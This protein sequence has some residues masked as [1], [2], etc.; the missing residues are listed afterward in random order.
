[1]SI[2]S[3]CVLTMA[4]LIGLVVVTALPAMAE[5][6]RFTIR[7][8]LVGMFP[9]STNSVDDGMG[10]RQRVDLDDSFGGEFDFEWYF[11]DRWGLEASILTVVDADFDADDLTGSDV[12][13]ASGLAIT[14]MTFGINWHAIRSESFDWYIGAVVG[15]IFYGDFDYLRIDNG[16]NVVTD[17]DY[18]AD[19]DVAYGLQTAVDLAVTKHGKWAVNIGLKYLKSEF[20]ADILD[21]SAPTG[22]R[23]DKIKID[24]WLL[25]VMGVFRF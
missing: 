17:S 13:T 15:P 21:P 10:G 7:F 11:A 16:N 1:M 14:P 18:K 3:K 20:D 6:E 4:A 24:P 8:G 12:I 5:G 19:A 22:T 25:R 9:S 23:T 2:K